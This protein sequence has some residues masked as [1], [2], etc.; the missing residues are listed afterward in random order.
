MRARVRLIQWDGCRICDRWLRVL[1]SLLLGLFV[2]GS[3]GYAAV[4]PQQR[5][6]AKRLSD[7]TRIAGQLYTEGKFVECAEKI[8]KIQEELA[9]LLE[10]KDPALQRLVKPIYSR[11]ARAHGLLEFEGAELEA[12]PSWT[13]LTE[14]DS[15]KPEMESVSFKEDIAPWFISACGNCHI[16]NSRGQFS[17]ATYQDL[18]RGAGGNAVLFAGS[19]RGSRLIEVIESGDMPRG[20]GQVT[21][22]QLVSLKTW[23]DQGA[24]FDGPSPTARLPEFVA[25]SNSPAA[26]TMSVKQATGSESVSFANDI[27][28]I[29]L[30]NCQGCHIGGRRASGGLRMDT[31]AQ[32]IRGGDSGE[33]IAGTNATTS[34]L[35]KKLKGEEGQRMPAGGRPALSDEKIALISTWITEGATFDGAAPNTNIETVVNEGWASGASH[36]ELFERR[37]QRMLDRWTRVLPG[38]EPGTAKTDEILVLGNVPPDRLEQTL[39]QVEGAVA[40][41]KKLLRAPSREPLIKGGIAVFVLKSRYDYSE[42]GRMTENRELPKEWMGHWQSDPLDVYA[43]MAAD[44]EIEPKQAEA[45]ALQVVAGAYL[46]SFREVPNWFA[47]G[48]ARNLVRTSHRRGD[49][50]ILVWQRSLPAAMQKVQNARSLLEDRLDEEASGLVGMALTNFMMDRANRRRFDKLLELMRA[51]RSFTDATTFAYAPP[52]ALVKAWLGK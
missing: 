10:S 26:S 41:T 25:G 18:M 17:M 44:T 15:P 33:L 36:E 20:G 47:E 30:E 1:G 51:G 48:V 16:N 3:L 31:F 34:L 2:L 46:G 8:T 9:T 27:A 5:A 40:Q 32:M 43:V 45:V 14:G 6:T 23:V 38:D 12:L 19:A 42:F 13:D 50:R 37:Q 22:E 29:L 52:E 11:L 35:V 28:P 4:T 49:D 39:K 21:P 7:E 24:K